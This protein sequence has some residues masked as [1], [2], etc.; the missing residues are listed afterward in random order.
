MDSFFDVY[1]MSLIKQGEELCGD[2]IKT[3]RTPDK[4]FIVLSDGLGSGVKANIL[5][6]MTTEIITTMMKADVPLQEVIS[7]V[8]ETL[9][10]CK[11]RKVAYATFTII[12]IHHDDGAFIVYNF[13]N[14][15]VFFFRRGHPCELMR[16]K[17]R[18]HDREIAMAHGKLEKGDF[19]GAISDGVL[20]AG[21]GV[22]LNFGWGW[23]RIEKFL[24]GLFI[25]QARNSQAIVHRTLAETRK[26]YH[27]AIGDDASFVG[28]YVRNR[29]ALAVFTGPPLDRDQDSIYAEKL[30]QFP[31]KRVICG[32]TTSNI[33]ANYLGEQVETDISTLREDVPPVGSLSQVDLL[34]E[35]IFTMSRSLELM[36]QTGG[37]VSRLPRDR[38][39]AVLLARE[40]L[41]ADSVTFLV[42]QRV[43]E[44]YQNP[45]LPRN[46]SIRR[47]LV[48]EIAQVLSDYNKD[49][50]IEFC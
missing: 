39:G 46:I 24:E 33:V 5:A 38:N 47:K 36:R 34:T 42:G 3:V 49:V 29:N 1:S 16:R 8:I 19:I 32:G 2:N 26:L 20:Y 27:E 11:V 23:D 50:D 13:D 35:G 28:V 30:L 17:E 37:E 48:E 22:E 41:S 12:E 21:L 4:T 31:G 44:F 25:T 18:I 10:I 40:L 9:P 14:P 7:T 6:T 43:N 45:L 15:P